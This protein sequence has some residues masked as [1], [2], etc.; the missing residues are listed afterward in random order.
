MYTQLKFDVIELVA[1]GA[2]QRRQG[3][4]RSTSGTHKQGCI[5]VSGHERVASST[6]RAEVWRP[7]ASDQGSGC[8]RLYHGPSARFI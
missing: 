6:G 3:Q 8:R 7:T 1:V 2:L 4:G 5:R